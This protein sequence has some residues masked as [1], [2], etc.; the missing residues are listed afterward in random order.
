MYA[1]WTCWARLPVSACHKLAVAGDWAW[2]GQPAS[3]SSLLLHGSAG[4]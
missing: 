3:L 4:L 2:H 1:K